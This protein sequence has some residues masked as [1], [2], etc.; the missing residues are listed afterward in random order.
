MM[1]HF[2][3]ELKSSLFDD[4]IEEG[5]KRHLELLHSILVEQFVSKIIFGMRIE[6]LR[7]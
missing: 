1:I 3:D 7:S 6:K 4:K 5:R 2:L